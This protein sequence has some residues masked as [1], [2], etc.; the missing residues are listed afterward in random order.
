MKPQ[1]ISP[2]VRRL[3]IK[4]Y[5]LDYWLFGLFFI[6]L[7]MALGSARNLTGLPPQF[8]C[9]NVMLMGGLGLFLLLFYGVSDIVADPTTRRL[10]LTTRRYLAPQTHEFGF[11][12]IAAVEVEKYKTKY[13]RGYVHRIV[14][15]TSRGETVPFTAYASYNAAG[16][17]AQANRLQ[18]FIA[19]P[20]TRSTT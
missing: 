13:D 1:P 9:L 8:Q 7:G 5:P 11:D 16:L 19:G 4:Q 10:T 14:L 18:T 20:T 17:Q 12:E 15:K 2:P 3:V 6:G